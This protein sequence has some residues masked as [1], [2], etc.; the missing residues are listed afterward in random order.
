MS[1]AEGCLLTIIIAAAHRAV[2]LEKLLES[3]DSPQRADDVE[4]IVVDQNADDRLARVIWRFAGRFNLRVLRIDEY[5]ANKARNYGASQANGEWLAFADDDCTYLENTIDAMKRII[6]TC[7]PHIIIGSVWDNEGR[8]LCGARR[9][10]GRL[11]AYNLYA[12][13]SETALLIRRSLFRELGG[14]DPDFGPGGKYYAGEGIELCYRALKR[15][16]EEAVLLLYH[17][18]IRV[19]HPRK[20]PPYT[21]AAIHKEVLYSYGVGTVFGNYRTIWSFAHI[22]KYNVKFL[23]KLA[24][25]KPALR[26]Y[27]VACFKGF[28]AGVLKKKVPSR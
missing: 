14:F 19:T 18:D 27:A 12:N 23:I 4:V 22:L 17:D 26:R 11:H 21:D 7:N 28:M 2:E 16:A 5:H 8:Y 6:R 15:K 9:G 10:H 24:V 13:M 20:I 25:F 3:L 1:Q